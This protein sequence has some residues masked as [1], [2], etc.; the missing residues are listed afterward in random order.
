MSFLDPVAVAKLESLAVRARF[1]VDGALTGMHRASMRGSSVEFAEHKEYSQGD[2]IRHIDWKVYAKADRYY[3]KQYEQESELTCYLVLDA[4]G[5][6]NYQGQGLSKRAYACNLL[7]AL[8]Y[9][10]VQQRDRVGLSIFGDRKLDRYVPPKSQP[11]HL[12]AILSAI[13]EIHARP[14][15]GDETLSSALGRVAELARRRRGLVVIASDLFDEDRQSLSVLKHLRA[16]GHDTVLFHTLDPDE[17]SFPF[18]EMTLFESLET[19]NQMLVDPASIRK[20]YQERLQRFLLE[21]KTAC[22]EAGIEYHLVSTEQPFEQSLMSFL[23]GR[24][25][26]AGAG[27]SGRR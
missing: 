7:A 6:M 4:S 2:E 17:I 10:L 5:S 12:R 20:I 13:E 1:I 15:E 16:R 21:T 14:H 19:P 9:L 11:A 24:L 18:D 22:Q 3:V 26:V 25:G 27:K 8:A 23:S